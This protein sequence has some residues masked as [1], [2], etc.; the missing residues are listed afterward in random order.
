MS[1]LQILFLV[2]SGGSIACSI[3]GAVAKRRNIGYII[4]SAMVAAGDVFCFVLLRA[5]SAKA[6][7]DILLPSLILNAWFLFAMLIMMILVDRKRRFTI[8][9]APAAVICLYQTYIVVSQ[10]LGKRIFIFRQKV[11]LGKSFWIAVE[12]SKNTGLLMSYRSYRVMTYIMI[13]IIVFALIGVLIKTNRVMIQRYIA[14]LIIMVTYGILEFLTIHYTFPIWIPQL[15]YNLISISCLYYMVYYASVRLRN[16]SLDNFANDMSDGL[17]LYDRHSDLIHINK[18][19]KDTLPENLLSDFKDQAKLKKWIEDLSAHSPDE[20]IKYTG[21]DRDYYFR[22][23]TKEFG[24]KDTYIGTLYILHDTT[25][26]VIRIRAMEKANAELERASRMKS[27]FLA[28]MSHEIRTPMNAVIGMA[29]IAMR[30]KEPVKV[31]DHLLQIQS[32]GKN[33][34][35]IINDILD[36]SKIESGKMEIIEDDYEPAVEAAEIANVLITRVGT[37]PL[38]LFMIIKGK[39]PRV[40]HGDA[41]RIR[42]VL[43]NLANNAIKFTKEGTVKIII[44]VEPMEDGRVNMVFHII[45]TGIGIRKE[46]L[47]K[48]FVSFQQLDSK[49]NRYVEGTGLGLAISQRLV[50][51]MGGTIGVS[52]EYGKGSDFWFTVPQTVVDPENVM[53]V[54][55][56][57]EKNTF[58]LNKTGIKAEMIEVFV[59][60]MENLGV[61]AVQLRDISELKQTGKKDFLFFREDD[62]DDSIKSFLDDNKNV[63]GIMLVDYASGIVPDKINLHLLRRPE[64]TM[65]MIA[66]LN[67]H[68]DE[69]RSIDS[70]KVFRYEYTAPNARILIVDDNEIN[71][72]I[73]EGLLAPLRIR[74]DKATGG[75]KAVEM[76]SATPYDIVFMDH[77]MPEIDGVDATKAIREK[78]DSIH[79]PVIIALSANVMEEAKKLFREAGMEDFVAKPV[80]VRDITNKIRKWLPEDKIVVGDHENSDLADEDD[81]IGP[82]SVCETIRIENLDVESA[83]KSFGSTALYDRIAAEYVRSGDDKLYGIRLAYEKEDWPDYTIKVHALK[84]SSRQIGAIVL[85]DRAEK[86]EKAGKAGN[87]DIIVSETG[88]TLEMF[89]SLIDSL[90]VYYGRDEDDTAKEKIDEEHLKKLLGELAIY[91]DDLDMDGMEKIGDELKKYT[92]DDDVNSDITRLLEAI[93]DMDTD[94]CMDVIGNLSGKNIN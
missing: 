57:G 64:T 14:M 15:A 68:Y 13:V 92:Y 1:V 65:G 56:A 62:Y 9:I 5:D 75:Q 21:N 69:T 81:G 27:D 72:S 80:D 12:D 45:D 30:E 33:L 6:A 49:R 37:K 3:I 47:C 91:C 43:I 25:D 82:R 35:N 8:M 32:S 79:Q 11:I 70:E 63:S 88:D 78:K 46:D 19:I 48:L 67:E 73:A 41:M 28:N 40:L 10:Y 22:L 31:L 58:I 94:V 66:V 85:G 86:L 71:I 42:Q 39:M 34:L 24:E 89:R 44:S 77:M 38:E 84:S 87:L 53:T 7:A 2:L 52:S 60:E 16:W 23:T 74:M 50:E 36:Y 18:M 29:E 51:A 90:K 4:T 17:I 20:F 26:Y 61:K 76:V 54:E 93:G 55:N 83:V 59:N